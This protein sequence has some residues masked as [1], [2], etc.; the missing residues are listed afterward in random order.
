[1]L[2]SILVKPELF[3]DDYV[4]VVAVFGSS[5]SAYSE[6]YKDSTL[7]NTLELGI[8]VTD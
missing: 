1:M 8:L 2:G 6:L 7:I 4:L 5:P 3:Y